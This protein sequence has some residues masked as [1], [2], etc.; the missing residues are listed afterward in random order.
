MVLLTC[1]CLNI[2]INV[3]FSENEYKQLQQHNDTNTDD[4][5]PTGFFPKGEVEVELDTTGIKQE[6]GYLVH[7]RKHGNY[8]VF[9]CLNCGLDSY[10]M[11]INGS[12]I[13]TSAQLK[14][15]S[16][17][18][19]RLQHLDDYSEVFK[20]VLANKDLPITKMP[21]PQSVSYEAVQ[22][23]LNVIQQQLSD[24]VIQEEAD[25]ENR[26]RQHE[27]SQREEFQDL[28][29]KLKEEK[30][31]M[32]SLLINSAQFDTVEEKSPRDSSK[33]STE[34]RR[35]PAKKKTVSRVKSLPPTLE[36]ESDTMFGFDG[37]ENTDETFYRDSS[38]ESD[39]DGADDVMEQRMSV[40]RKPNL[41]Y[42]SSVPISMPAWNNPSRPDPLEEEEDLTPSDPSQIAAS[43]QAL[44]QSITDDHRYIFGDRPRPRLNTGDF[45]R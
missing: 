26:I 25:M 38:S 19:D 35:T 6:H 31:R 43:M 20:I 16:L 30:K 4:Y 23:T 2:K 17:V 34:A 13:I 14:S 15:E 10:A 39:R 45:N 7:R 8:M 28:Q 44:A 9:R 42:S 5:I 40:R 32:I 33:R 12:P 37:L 36:P 27:E 21:D 1:D 18:I 22:S 11:H 24:F 41:T 3:K 29:T